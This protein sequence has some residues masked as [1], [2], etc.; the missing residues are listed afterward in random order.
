MDFQLEDIVL[1]GADGVC[2]VSEITERVIDKA[3]EKYYI[4]RPL[5][6]KKSTIFVPQSNEKLIGRMREPA[7]KEEIDAAL[8]AAVKAECIWI[9]SDA[10]RKVGFRRIIEGGDVTQILVLFKSLYFHRDKQAENG[11]K[12]HVADERLLKNADKV[13]CDVFSY[14]LGMQRDTVTGVIEEKLGITS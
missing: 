7:S 5:Y 13:L 3:V 9:D 1:Y 14:V 8:K 6:D 4:L 12:L 11:K 10:D 2:K